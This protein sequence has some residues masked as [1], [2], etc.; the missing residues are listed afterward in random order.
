[1]AVHR[2]G[3]VLALMRKWALFLVDCAHDLGAVTGS[4]DAHADQRVWA[5]G[6]AK[7]I[8]PGPNGG[9]V[10]VTEGGVARAEHAADDGV[11]LGAAGEDGMVA[12]AAVVAGI[13]TWQSTLVVAEDRLD[14]GV[15]VQVKQRAS[16]GPHWSKAVLGHHLLD[17]RD[18]L[19]VEAA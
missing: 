15:H 2:S 8:E 10:G 11:G 19:V 16:P 13:G 14:G 7:A 18:G 6:V 9:S 4:I 1:M 17:I 3:V 5:G 12:G